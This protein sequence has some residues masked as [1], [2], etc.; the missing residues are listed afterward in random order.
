MGKRMSG[1][2]NSVLFSSN[3]PVYPFSC[4]PILLP[5]E[6]ITVLSAGFSRLAADRR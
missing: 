6:P 5:F 2:E 3:F 4:P 1:Q